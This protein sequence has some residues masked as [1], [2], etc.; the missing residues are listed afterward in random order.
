MLPAVAPGVSKAVETTQRLESELG[1]MRSKIAHVGAHLC[2]D[3]AYESVGV[4]GQGCGS[5]RGA[6]AQKKAQRHEC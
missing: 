3:G 6:H 2:F 1:S 5:T 4:E